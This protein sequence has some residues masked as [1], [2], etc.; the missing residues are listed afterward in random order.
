[1]RSD[2]K[3][4]LYILI[5]V[6]AAL[7]AAACALIIII[8]SPAAA[9][10]VTEPVSAEP[11]TYTKF[12]DGYC[13]KLLAAD[14]ESVPFD[15]N[16]FFDESGTAWLFLPAEADGDKLKIRIYDEA[17][18]ET[19]SVSVKRS[20]GSMSKIEFENT[21]LS[22]GIMQTN[23]PSLCVDLDSGGPSLYDIVSDKQ[24]SLIG[25]GNSSLFVPS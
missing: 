19:G 14:N 7:I 6:A 1:M 22:L 2:S 18:N 3:T 13:I 4:L 9:P 12:Y 25:Y 10:D 11:M 21:S 20:P 16:A 23:L 17:S 5:P 24:K 15:I 8:N